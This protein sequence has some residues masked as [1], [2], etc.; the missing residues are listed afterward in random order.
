M[1][2][3][4]ARKDSDSKM[5]YPEDLVTIDYKNRI[6]KVKNHLDSR[7][8]KSG[9]PLSYVICLA[10]ADPAEAPDEPHSIEMTI[11][12]CITCL[13]IYWLRP[14]DRHGSRR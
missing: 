2:T 3:Q 12:R 14:K 5:Y 11:V 1:T 13:R 4:A 8:G 6:K 9:A 7:T 10:N